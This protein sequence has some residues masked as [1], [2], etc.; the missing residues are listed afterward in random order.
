[1]AN[2]FKLE[3]GRLVIQDGTTSVNGFCGREDILSVEIPDSVTEIAIGAFQRCVNLVDVKI[4]DSGVDILPSAFK[5]CKSL[6]SI[7]VPQGNEELGDSTFAGCESLE[8][9]SLPDTLERI[10][11]STFGDCESLKSIKFPESLIDIEIYA[12][13]NCTS[14]KQIELPASI[15][16]FDP[17]AFAGCDNIK[18]VIL[19][20]DL[21]EDEIAE[22]LPNAK[23]VKQ[24]PQ[25]YKRPE[26]WDEKDDECDNKSDVETRSGKDI[27]TGK[28]NDKMFRNKFEEWAL[29]IILLGCVLFMLYGVILI[30]WT[31]VKSIFFE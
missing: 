27:R 6:V 12:F 5:D 23:I 17:Q 14:L 3:N 22:V 25:G 18:K 11:V 29:Y 2:D 7:S 31:I 20:C 30:V 1:M 26:V 15:I 10:C 4:P 13:E 19:H 24:L 8:N 21:D 28:S 16:W 9:V